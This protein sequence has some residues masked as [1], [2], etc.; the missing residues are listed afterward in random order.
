MQV[1]L[2]VVVAVPAAH[3]LQ[4]EVGLVWV[5][6]LV[7]ESVEV[8]ACLRVRLKE[9]WLEQTKRKQALKIPAVLPPNERH[10]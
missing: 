9:M 6:A 1:L 3:Q 2:A 4:M 8:L 5:L 10:P 7:V